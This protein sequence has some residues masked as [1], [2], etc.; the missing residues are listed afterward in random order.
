MGRLTFLVSSV[1]GFSQ[2]RRYSLSLSRCSRIISVTLFVGGLLGSAYGQAPSSMSADDQMGLQPYQSYHGGEIDSVGLTN[3]TLS[4]HLPFLSYPQR[5]ELKLSFDLMYNNQ[6][7][8]SGYQ[9]IT[10]GGRTLCE[11]IWNYAV[12]GSPLPIEKGDVFVGWAQQLALTGQGQCLQN[13]CGSG[14]QPYPNYYANWSL[15]TADGSKHILANLG[16][17]T[18]FDD[19]TAGKLEDQTGPFETLDATGWKV[20]QPL[21]VTFPFSSQGGSFLTSTLT[22]VIGPDGVTYGAKVTDPNGNYITPN[23]TNTSFTDSIGRVIPAPPTA[24][25]SGNT[26][27]AACPVLGGSDPSVTFAVSWTPPGYNN[28]QMVYTFC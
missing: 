8:H 1:F 6:P 18:L 19:G 4:L 15:Q 27:T 2:I 21:N 25:S 10:E 13:T 3:G 26:S 17:M 11:W 5:G 28:G 20:N 12:D 14:V 24:A 9:C 22:S 23:S 7:Q 16:S